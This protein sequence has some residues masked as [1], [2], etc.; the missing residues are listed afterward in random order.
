MQT[1]SIGIA[2]SYFGDRWTQPY[3]A[4]NGIDCGYA[5]KF[6]PTVSLGVLMN[7]R[8][9]LTLH[10][11][12]FSVTSSI[13]G[14]YSPTPGMSY[15]LVFDGIGMGNTYLHNER[16]SILKYKRSLEKSIRIGTAFRFPSIY[17]EPFITIIMESQKI[18]DRS[19]IVYRAGFETIQ[20]KM[21][22]LRCGIMAR[23]EGT[24]GTFGLGISIDKLQIDYA[25]S[26]SRVVEQYHQ[27]SL[28]YQMSE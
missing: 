7:F 20:M 17:R 4:Y 12:L 24:A 8:N 5:V 3:F 11:S 6:D 19:G 13:G 9:G 21:L 22:F 18:L 27:I 26:P 16:V 28:S 10:H 2:G 14:F 25:L 1:I 23:R 15:G